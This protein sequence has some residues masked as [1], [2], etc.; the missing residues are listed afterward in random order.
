M[1]LGA[2]ALMN[3]PTR[4]SRLPIYTTVRHDHRWQRALATGPAM[5]IIDV[6]L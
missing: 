2:N 6:Q 5:K 4:L 1:M 3:T